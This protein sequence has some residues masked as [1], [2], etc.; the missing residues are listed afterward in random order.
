MRKTIVRQTTMRICI[1][2]HV[3]MDQESTVSEI[4]IITQLWVILSYGHCLA[5]TQLKSRGT[6]TNSHTVYKQHEKQTP[7]PQPI[8]IYIFFSLLTIIALHCMPLPSY[9]HTYTNI[10]LAY[11]LQCRRRPTGHN[12]QYMCNYMRRVRTNYGYLLYALTRAAYED[13]ALNACKT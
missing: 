11:C 8:S 6:H 1:Q 4:D 13:F 3:C 10:R 9:T 2:I 7:M 12:G 5:N